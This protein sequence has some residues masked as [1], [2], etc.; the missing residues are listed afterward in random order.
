MAL[1][2]PRFS[3]TIRNSDFMSHFQAL[4]FDEAHLI[5][6]WGENFREAYFEV[7]RLRS[8]F[9]Q[10]CPVLAT[11]ATATPRDIKIIEQVLHLQPETMYFVNLGN[12]R[13]NISQTVKQIRSLQQY[14]EIYDIIDQGNSTLQWPSIMIFANTIDEVRA[15]THSLQRQYPERKELVDS[16]HSR[17]RRPTK[18][19]VMERFREGETRILCTTE[20]AGMVC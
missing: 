7:G 4:I 9:P 6:Q 3:R 13:P 19:K 17:R 11:T 5:P 8:L 18:Q 2:H 1:Y 10:N 16:Y 15:I 12:D 20:A 14:T